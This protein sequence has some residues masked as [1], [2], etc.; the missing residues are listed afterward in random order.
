M[1]ASK[2]VETREDSPLVFDLAD[3]AAALVLIAS[4]IG[5]RLAAQK[6]SNLYPLY[7]SQSYGC[8]APTL[9]IITRMSTVPNFRRSA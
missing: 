7:I 1:A 5:V 9:P 3:K 4:Q 8:Q 2:S 6:C